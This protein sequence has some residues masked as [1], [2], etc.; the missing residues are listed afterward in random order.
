MNKFLIVLLILCTNN[1]FAALNKWVDEKGKVHYSDQPPP[2]N[3]Q[4]TTLHFAPAPPV[5]SAVPAVS[6]PVA[7]PVS[8]PAATEPQAKK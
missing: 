6:T 8:S 7:A 1:T 2:V 4:K 3:V 5:P